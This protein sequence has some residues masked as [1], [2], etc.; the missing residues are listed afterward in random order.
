MKKTPI[1]RKLIKNTQQPEVLGL[2][3]DKVRHISIQLLS[4]IPVKTRVFGRDQW[5]EWAGSSHVSGFFAKVAKCR[6]RIPPVDVDSRAVPSGLAL[7]EESWSNQQAHKELSDFRRLLM[8][9]IVDRQFLLLCLTT[10]ILE[11][12][13]W[14]LKSGKTCLHRETGSLIRQKGNCF[15]RQLQIRENCQMGNQRSPLARVRKAIARNSMAE[16]LRHRSLARAWYT[17]TVN[18]LVFGKEVAVPEWLGTFELWQG[19]APR[20]AFKAQI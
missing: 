20:A 4:P 12:L 2:R 5:C 1:R 17:N 9:K 16:W 7:A 3:V 10:G 19:P 13:W 11:W 6:D 15:R 18:R 14:R 8:I